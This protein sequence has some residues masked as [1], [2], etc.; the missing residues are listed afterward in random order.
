MNATGGPDDHAAAKAD[1][2][3]ISKEIK[4]FAVLGGPAQAPEFWRQ[5]AKSKILCIGACTTAQSQDLDQR[6][7]PRTS[8]RPARHPS[9]PTS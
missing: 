6:E 1:A 4:P 2:V 9:S 3:K 8:G 7:R 5:L